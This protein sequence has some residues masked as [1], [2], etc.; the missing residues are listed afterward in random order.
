MHSLHLHVC[1]TNSSVLL[2]FSP[3]TVIKKTV[4]E[5][6]ITSY[7]QQLHD[8]VRLYKYSIYKLQMELKYETIGV[9]SN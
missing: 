6:D 8:K 2:R 7:L 1:L 5:K 3:G 9:Y 4:P